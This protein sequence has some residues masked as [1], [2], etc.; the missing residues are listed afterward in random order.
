MIVWLASYPRSGNTFLRVI[1]YHAFGLQTYSLYGDLLDI[2][3]HSA[4]AELVGHA[5]LPSNW[6]AAEASLDKE[7][8]LVKTHDVPPTEDKA[9]YIIRDGREAAVSYVNYLHRYVRQDIELLDV[10]AGAVSFGSWSDHIA[11][12]APL[13]RKGTLLLRFEDLVTR[14]DAY[15]S[16]LADFLE[17]EPITPSLPTFAQLHTINPSFFPSGKKDTWK[18]SLSEELHILYWL[19]HRD[20]MIRYGYADN[21]PSLFEAAATPPEQKLIALAS[22][23][24]KAQRQ[25]LVRWQQQELA[26]RVNRLHSELTTARETAQHYRGELAEL[27]QRLASSEADRAMSSQVIKEQGQR[28]SEIEIERDGLRQVIAEQTQ[29]IG[30]VEAQR[31]SL[32]RELDQVGRQLQ[33]SEALRAS[34]ALVIGTQEQQLQTVTAQLRMFQDLY[35]TIQSGRVY[36]VTRRLGGWKW[37]EDTIRATAVASPSVEGQNLKAETPIK[38]LLQNLPPAPPNR[39]GW[40]WTETSPALPSVMPDGSPWPRISIVTPSYNQGKYIEETLRSVL[41]QGYPNLEY[42][43]IDGGSTDE[44]ADIINRYAP[45]LTYWV[46]EKDRG[47]S[48]AINKGWAHASGEIWAWLN[49][50][51]MYLPGTLAKIAEDFHKDPSARVLYGSALFVDENG[52]FR[53][54]Y[55]GRPLRPG[56]SRMQYWRG[57]DIPQP[58]LFFDSRLM[59]EYGPLDESYHYALDYE[60]IIRVSQHV[61]LTCLEDTL[62]VYRM[63]SESKTGDWHSTKSRFFI[64][65]ER[66]NRKHAPIW[67]PSSWPLWWAKRKYDARE[68]SRR[69]D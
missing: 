23:G 56:V 39:T 19:M 5:Y 22:W 38:P 3:S 42:V 20:A 24:V 52:Q 41:L 29:R 65:N 21:P 33:Q 14:P 15:I 69:K 45:W 16:I 27:H 8:W 43:V 13:E 66:A 37:V 32:H 10:I 68:S 28:I 54:K 51:D 11:A 25:A 9:I 47:Q 46:S 7:L 63:H 35:R 31:D 26:Q 62:A 12:W 6:N 57:W 18:S 59:K 30:A 40:P 34:Q 49:S 44:S 48:H 58:T 2:G 55:E 67:R 17:R 36:K 4:T 1:L 53:F 60:W 64:E 50:D 61:K